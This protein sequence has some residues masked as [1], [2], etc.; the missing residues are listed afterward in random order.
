MAKARGLLQRG[1]GKTGGD[2]LRRSLEKRQRLRSPKDKNR[3]FNPAKVFAG[4]CDRRRGCEQLPDRVSVVEKHLSCS[5]GKHLEAMLL[6]AEDILDPE[7]DSVVIGT[8]LRRLDRRTPALAPN[9]EGLLVRR[10]SELA[11]VS[12]GHSG[13]TMEA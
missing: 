13:I 1:V 4:Q 10:L 3:R 9:R 5:L 6:H 8:A 11:P 2:F 7:P 12:P